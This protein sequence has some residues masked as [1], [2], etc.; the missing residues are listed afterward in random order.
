VAL[1][2]LDHFKHINDTYGHAAGDAVLKVFADVLRESL[3]DTDTPARIGGEE[4]AVLLTSTPQDE[5]F[6]A[7]ERI[8]AAL[9]Q[10]P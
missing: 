9:D 10:R 1:M 8:R 7:L 5:A 4:F 2:D 3:R 6:V